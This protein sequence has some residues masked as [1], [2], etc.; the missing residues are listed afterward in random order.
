[1]AKL[2]P[3]NMGRLRTSG[4]D[5]RGARNAQ[6]LQSILAQLPQDLA[7]RV[8]PVAVDL[9]L[10]LTPDERLRVKPAAAVEDLAT[11]ATLADVIAAHNALLASL[12]AARLLEE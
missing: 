2:G 12:R 1:V 6:D 9:P 3:R 10:T 7:A 11:T 4:K 8:L 5:A